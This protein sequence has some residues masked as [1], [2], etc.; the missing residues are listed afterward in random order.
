MSEESSLLA[1]SNRAL[2]AWV[3]SGVGAVI[4]TSAGGAAWATRIDDRL[5]RAIV[6]LE[7][8]ADEIERRPTAA[9]INL[10]WRTVGALN[11]DLNLGPVL[12]NGDGR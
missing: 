12:D 5:E 6:G 3:A 1:K 9:E 10:Q 8:V 4:L 7:R 2:L 11:P